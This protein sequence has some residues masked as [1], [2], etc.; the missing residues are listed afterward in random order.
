MDKMRK[1]GIIRYSG[2][3]A[4]L[5]GMI[6][7]VLWAQTAIAADTDKVFKWKMQSI[8]PPAMLGASITQPAFCENIKKMS[9]GRLD[10]KL[11][12]AGQLTPT[13][14]IPGALKGGMVDISYTSN[15]YYTGAVPEAGLSLVSLP[16]F[17]LETFMDA[18]HV[19]WYAGIDD[20]LRQAW[21]EQGIYY[22][23][24]LVCMDPC[25]NWSKQPL[26][27]VEE[28]KGHK[29]RS[30][31]YLAK[32][33]AKLG[34]TPTFVPHEEVYTSLAQGILDGSS[35]FGSYYK[36]MK[37]YEVCPYYYQPGFIP[38]DQMCVLVSMSSWNK[39]PDDLKSMLKTA[40]SAY[41][42]DNAQRLWWAH[43]E[44][45]RELPKFGSTLMTWSKEDL[46]KVRKIS[47]SFLPEIAAKSPKNAKGIKII[48]DYMK[49]RGYLDKG[50]TIEKEK[51][52]Q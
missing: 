1:K 35:T 36:R 19:L 49:E 51:A 33:Y 48:T 22:L 52:G 16:P 17:L 20:I 6:V 10:I 31:G 4:F 34:A 8:D 14:E 45:L 46:E 43:E 30:F 7:F 28:F 38:V 21:A 23:G 37:Y 27:N 32:T 13:L 40:F 42:I 50:W 11:F 44:M 39:L 26:R 24:S 5:A 25:T 3:V 2:A 41:S 12:T 29:I 15:V 47:L 9:S 18:T